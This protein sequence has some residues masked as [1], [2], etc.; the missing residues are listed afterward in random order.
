MTF[1]V[2]TS[3]G[4]LQAV[5]KKEVG[6]VEDGKEKDPGHRDVL[7]TTVLEPGGRTVSLEDAH[8]LEEMQLQWKSLGKKLSIFST[9]IYK[10]KVYLCACNRGQVFSVH[11]RVYSGDLR[12]AQSC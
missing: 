10:E 9:F 4:K 12:H 8:F 3:I 2:L 5:P 6:R 11:L 1:T 7:F